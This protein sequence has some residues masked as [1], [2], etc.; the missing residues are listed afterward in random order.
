M[1]SLKTI[2]ALLSFEHRDSYGN[3]AL[4][5]SLGE[6]AETCINPKL[7]SEVS[8][9]PVIYQRVKT[10]V[11]ESSLFRDFRR[12]CVETDSISDLELWYKRCNRPISE[13]RNVFLT[14]PMLLANVLGV[15]YSGEF[16][17]LTNEM[18]TYVLLDD[19]HCPRC[20]HLRSNYRHLDLVG[21]KRN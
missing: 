5:V 9:V 7:A 4:A 8:S 18:I 6:F 13:M 20:N 1:P 17:K 14:A 16:Q 15:P 19:C 21:E 2:A 3:G 10:L 11:S 12:S